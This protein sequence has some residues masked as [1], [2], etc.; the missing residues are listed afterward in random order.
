MSINPQINRAIKFEEKFTGADMLR[1]DI[2]NTFGN[3]KEVFGNR[4]QWFLDNEQDLLNNLDTYVE[5]ADEPLMFKKAVL[6]YADAKKGLPVYHNMFMDATASGPQIMAVLSGCPETALQVNLINNGLRNDAYAKPIQFMKEQF[7]FEVSRAD[8]KK[9]I[10]THFYNSKAEPYRV[11]EGDEEKLDAFY[12]T[13]EETFPGAEAVLA[14]INDAWDNN[15]MFHQWTLPDGHV[16]H[17]K[18][19]EAVDAKIELNEY[20]NKSFTYRFYN[21]EPSEVNTSLAPNIIHS[22]DAYIV[23]EVTRR[24]D[25]DVAHIHDAFTASPNN[26]PK[27]MDLYREILAELAERNLLQDIIQEI[28]GREEE[29]DKYTDDLASHIRNSEYALS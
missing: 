20:E 16:A 23:R 18:V 21:N 12:A 7:G 6:A 11:F 8:M 17:V 5:Q 2:S 4:I 22:I 26:M 25:F 13:M 14:I 10:M 9:A 3:D 1:I 19:K 24:A 28:T 27:V 15:A 29:L